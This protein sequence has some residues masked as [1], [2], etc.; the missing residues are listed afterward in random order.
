MKKAVGDLVLALM[1][2]MSTLAF[3]QDG[4]TRI[5]YYNQT[6]QTVS[7][8]DNGSPV[9]DVIPN[10]FT[11]ESVFPGTHNLVASEPNGSVSRTIGLEDGHTFM[12]TVTEG[13]AM[14]NKNPDLNLVLASYTQYDGFAVN[15][16]VPLVTTEPQQ[17]TTHA[18]HTFTYKQYEGDM[19]NTDS[20]LVG[21]YVYDF[22]LTSKDLDRYVD[23]FAGGV[24]G[25]VISRDT[26]FNISGLPA[27]MA[28]ITGTSEGRAIRYAVAVTYKGNRAFAFVFGSF[29]DVVS[30][31]EEFKTFFNSASIN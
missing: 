6:S 28:V 12:W 9:G 16:P 27:E 23:G 24:N 19:P 17:R 22:A 13:N 3:A 26:D 7:F 21:V 15:A 20:Y 11:S 31:G 30:N 4:R 29:V 5:E 8:S 14:L 1:F 25:T 10:G 18:G 2:L